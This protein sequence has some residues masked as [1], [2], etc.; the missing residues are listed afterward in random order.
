MDSVLTNIRKHVEGLIQHHDSIPDKIIAG[1]FGPYIGVAAVELVKLG[2]EISDQLPS[3]CQ[4]IQVMQTIN[5][6]LGFVRSSENGTHRDAT[7]SAIRPGSLDGSCTVPFALRRACELTSRRISSWKKLES[8]M[9]WISLQC[10]EEKLH[11]ATTQKVNHAYNPFGIL[12]FSVRFGEKMELVG[13][14]S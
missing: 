10:T 11:S 12:T 13:H 1:Q 2:N 14:S 9:F 6:R 8:C 3:S 7:L 5:M 4:E